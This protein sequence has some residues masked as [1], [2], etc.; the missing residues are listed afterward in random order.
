[1]QKQIMMTASRGEVCTASLAGG[2]LCLALA[3]LLRRDIAPGSY[4]RAKP[5][6]VPKRRAQEVLLVLSGSK[7][8]TPPLRHFR[9]NA[10]NHR[11]R[12]NSSPDDRMTTADTLEPCR[13]EAG[14]L[15]IVVLKAQ[16]LHDRHVTPE[17]QDPFVEVEVTNSGKARTAAD[18]GGGEHPCEWLAS[19]SGRDER[20]FENTGHR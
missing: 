1:M 5:S 13:R 4:I 16:Y 10:V 15:V 19:A 8:L 17:T 12:P 3:T 18:L 9:I 7:S 6:L 20:T 11:E 2:A 14:L